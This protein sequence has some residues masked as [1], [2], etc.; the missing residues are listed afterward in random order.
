MTRQT[1][2]D[3]KAESEK[4]QGILTDLLKDDDNKYCADCDAKGPR[5]ASWNLGVF[6]CIRCAG[7]HRNLGCH[8]SKVRSVNLDSWT[9]EQIAMVQ[10]IGNSRGRAV[11]EANLPDHFR[12]PQTDSSLEAFIRAKYEQKKYIAKEWIPPQHPKLKTPVDDKEKAVRK[13]KARIKQ[14][15]P[16]AVAMPS[17]EATISNSNKVKQPTSQAQ[18]K[19]VKPV[20]SQSAS[21][22]LLGLEDP[23]STTGQQL[24]SDSDFGDFMSMPPVKSTPAE[25]TSNEK[26]LSD[27]FGSGKQPSVPL[28]DSKMSTKDI[29]ALY[30]D[31]V[32]S[33]MNQQMFAPMPN[34]SLA[35][36]PGIPPQTQP[37]QQFLANQSM[38]P[39]QNMMTQGIGMATCYTAT[40]NPYQQQQ[41][42]QQQF[43]MYPAPMMQNAAN[44]Q[45]NMFAMQ[46]QMQHQM[47]NI[48]INNQQIPYQQ[49][50]YAVAQQFS[51]QTLSN[52]LWQSL[53]LSIYLGALLF[54]GGLRLADGC[55]CQL[56][57]KNPCETKCASSC[58]ECCRCVFWYTGLKSKVWEQI[59]QPT[60][61]VGGEESGIEAEKRLMKFGKRLLHFEKK[62][63][64]FEKKGLHFEKR[65][66]V[67]EKKEVDNFQ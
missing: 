38:M 27:L 3:K 48:N 50:N 18:E 1:E 6:L 57:Y 2:R 25:T 9:A 12:R 47:A 10:E 24:Q 62:P 32:P 63:V 61:K 53:H 11:Y 44:G 33:S 54:V 66:I 35:Y 8:I 36:N 64:V 13:T 17:N 4:Y 55:S 26:E 15:I 5:W 7:I 67:Y 31:A 30:G 51:G 29:M 39:Q 40:P 42:Q 22:D 20:N 16:P 34:T 49:A 59:N 56:L 41:Q 52:N 19:V 14:T 21:A 45:N 65:P 28:N 58:V 43:N 60:T 37:Q 46:Q 23:A